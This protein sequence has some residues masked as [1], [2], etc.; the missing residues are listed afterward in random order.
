M[1]ALATPGTS[2]ARL[3]Q[4][5]AA[6]K[7]T[8]A[9]CLPAWL[10]LTRMRLDR[11]ASPLPFLGRLMPRHEA[12]ESRHQWVHRA[13]DRQRDIAGEGA[14]SSVAE[15]E[16][17]VLGDPVRRAGSK[18]GIERRGNGRCMLQTCRPD[19]AAIPV[20]D[21]TR[22]TARAHGR[23]RGQIGETSSTRSGYVAV[24]TA[25][26]RLGKPCE[27]SPRRQTCGDWPVAGRQ[28]VFA[29]H[30]AVGQVR[31][32]VIPYA[33]K[34]EAASNFWKL[35]VIKDCSFSRCSVGIFAR[36]PSMASRNSRKVA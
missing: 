3:S 24:S 11:P 21:A 5:P 27:T 32:E 31:A 10:Q 20:L 2:R 15:A 1:L 4:P 29:L 28:R 7:R 22:R 19:A 12:V 18:G 36:Q 16:P 26:I 25:T 17:R 23:R 9:A 8:R 13:A 34:N 35:C 33:G 30:V 6:I 14:V